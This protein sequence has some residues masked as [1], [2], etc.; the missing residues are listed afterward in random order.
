MPRPR[1]PAVGVA[2]AGRRSW[3]GRANVAGLACTLVLSLC[4]TADALLT[5]ISLRE[6][7]NLLALT[8]LAWSEKAHLKPKCRLEPPAFVPNLLFYVVKCPRGTWQLDL[9]ITGTKIYRVDG[10]P[11]ESPPLYGSSEPQPWGTVDVA[12]PAFDM[13]YMQTVHSCPEDAL[14]WNDAICATYQFDVYRIGGDL[15]NLNMLAVTSDVLSTL[16]PPFDPKT[17]HYTVTLFQNQPFAISANGLEPRTRVGIQF[18]GPASRSGLGDE[19]G[20]HIASQQRRIWEIPGGISGT[21]NF[22]YEVCALPGDGNEMNSYFI[23]VQVKPVFSAELSAIKAEGDY[24]LVPPFHV[25]IRSYQILVP[26]NVAQVSLTVRT[27][28]PEAKIS[29]TQ[30]NETGT[31]HRSGMTYAALMPTNT[32]ISFMKP[33]KWNTAI[34]LT[35]TSADGGEEQTVVVNLK[36]VMSSYSKLKNIT[37]GNGTSCVLTP[38]FQTNITQYRCVFDWSSG[39]VG[40]LIPHMDHHH[41]GECELRMPDPELEKGKYLSVVLREEVTVKWDDTEKWSRE[42]LYGES[43]HVQF[44]VVSADRYTH[45]IYDVEVLRDAPWWMRTQT[46]RTVAWWSYGLSTL[47]ALSNPGNFMQ[48]TKYVQFM[49]LT[50]DIDGVPSAYAD[51][52]HNLDKGMQIPSIMPSFDMGL[53]D[54]DDFDKMKEDMIQQIKDKAGIE[55]AKLLLQYCFASKEYGRIAGN[56]I[57]GHHEDDTKE[58]IESMAAAKANMTKDKTAKTAKDGGAEDK[59]AAKGEA[60]TAEDRLLLETDGARLRGA[61]NSSNSFGMG[62]D[63]RGELRSAISRLLSSDFE[64]WEGFDASRSLSEQSNPSAQLRRLDDEYRDVWKWSDKHWAKYIKEETDAGITMDSFPDLDCASQPIIEEIITYLML[65]HELS[66]LKQMAHSTTGYFIFTILGLVTLGSSYLMYYR[67]VMKGNQKRPRVFEPTQMWIFILDYALITFMKLCTKLIFKGKVIKIM[68]YSPNHATTVVVCY[69]LMIAYPICFVL[70]VFW[71]VNGLISQR[72]LV[73]DKDTEAWTDPKCTTLKITLK[74]KVPGFI[75]LLPQLMTNHVRSCVPILN[76]EGDRL[77]FG[78]P[79]PG[80]E[81]EDASD[82]DEGGVQD[83][84]DLEKENLEHIA[85]VGHTP[86]SMHDRRKSERLLRELTESRAIKRRKDEHMTALNKMMEDAKALRTNIEVQACPPWLHHSDSERAHHPVPEDEGSAYTVFSL[87]DLA[88]QNWKS[89]KKRHDVDRLDDEEAFALLTFVNA[90]IRDE[91]RLAK[92]NILTVEPHEGYLKPREPMKPDSLVPKEHQNKYSGDN[93]WLDTYDDYEVLEGPFDHNPWLEEFTA[94]NEYIE[95]KFGERLIYLGDDNLAKI[96]WA[97]PGGDTGGKLD[98]LSEPEE[99]WPEWEKATMKKAH[100]GGTAPDSTTIRYADKWQWIVYDK[101]ECPWY[102]DEADEGGWVVLGFTIKKESIMF[103]EDIQHGLKKFFKGRVPFMVPLVDKME[104]RKYCWA[105]LMVAMDTKLKILWASCQH[106]K[107]YKEQ[108]L[109]DLAMT[110]FHEALFQIELGQADPAKL[111]PHEQFVVPQE[112]LSY[113]IMKYEDMF[114]FDKEPWWGKCDVAKDGE[115]KV[116]F[117]HNLFW[118]K[119]GDEELISACE[120]DELVPATG[121]ATSPY[122]NQYPN[123]DFGLKRFV[124]LKPDGTQTDVEIG[125]QMKHILPLM[126]YTDRFKVSVPVSMLDLEVKNSMSIILGESKYGQ[127][128]KYAFERLTTLISILILASHPNGLICC[129]SVLS[130]ELMTFSYKLYASIKARRVE[131]TGGGGDDAGENLIKLRRVQHAEPAKE[132]PPSRENTNGKSNAKKEKETNGNKVAPEGGEVDPATDAEDGGTKELRRQGAVISENEVFSEAGEFED[133]E[134]EEEV[135]AAG[136]KPLQEILASFNDVDV[137]VYFLRCIVLSLLLVAQLKNIIAPAICAV[138][139][140]YV[141]SLTMVYM[142]VACFKDQIADVI[143][144]QKESVTAMYTTAWLQYVAIRVFL[145]GENPLGMEI[146]PF[147]AGNTSSTRAEK[148][149]LIVPQLGITFSGEPKDDPMLPIEEQRELWLTKKMAFYVHHLEGDDDS[150]PKSIRDHD[151]Y[152]H[153]VVPSLNVALSVDQMLLRQAIPQIMATIQCVNHSSSSKISRPQYDSFLTLFK[154]EDWEP[155]FEQDKEKVQQMLDGWSRQVD[156]WFAEYLG[157]VESD[158][159]NTKHIKAQLEGMLTEECTGKMHRDITRIRF[160]DVSFPKKGSWKAEDLIDKVCYISV[161]YDTESI[162][163]V[164]PA[165]RMSHYSK[166]VAITEEHDLTA[167]SDGD[168][169][170]DNKLSTPQVD[171]NDHY[172]ICQ[173]DSV[174]DVPVPLNVTKLQFVLWAQ[175][176]DKREELIC[177]SS[178]V[179][180]KELPQLRTCSVLMHTLWSHAGRN[181]SPTC[182]EDRDPEVIKREQEGDRELEMAKTPWQKRKERMTKNLRWFAGCQFIPYFRPRSDASKLRTRGVLRIKLLEMSHEDGQEDVKTVTAVKNVIEGDSA[183]NLGKLTRHMDRWIDLGKFFGVFIGAEELEHLKGHLRKITK[184]NEEFKAQGLSFEEKKKRLEKAEVRRQLADQTEMDLSLANFAADIERKD[185]QLKKQIENGIEP[186]PSHRVETKT[187]SS[188]TVYM[189][190]KKGQS[191]WPFSMCKKVEIE[192]EGG[193]HSTQNY[194]LDQLR[195]Y[196]EFSSASAKQILHYVVMSE[197]LK[198]S[199]NWR[200]DMISPHVAYM[201]TNEYDDVPSVSLQWVERFH[202]HNV[203]FDRELQGESTD[204]VIVNGRLCFKA[205]GEDANRVVKGA[206]AVYLYWDGQTRW[207]ISPEKGMPPPYGIRGHDASKFIWV[208]DNKATPDLIVEPWHT[209]PTDPSAVKKWIQDPSIGL[210]RFD[211]GKPK[212]MFMEQANAQMAEQQEGDESMVGMVKGIIKESLAEIILMFSKAGGKKIEPELKDC[213]VSLSTNYITFSWK[214]DNIDRLASFR[215][216]LLKE[217]GNYESAWVHL[218]RSIYVPRPKARTNLAAMFAKTEKLMQEAVESTK[219]PKVEKLQSM[220]SMNIE[221]LE[222]K[223]PLPV[224]DK[225]DKFGPPWPDDR[226]RRMREYINNNPL[227]NSLPTGDDDDAGQLSRKD[228]ALLV[229]EHIAAHVMDRLDHEKDAKIEAQEVRALYEGECEDEVLL[230]FRDWLMDHPI[231]HDFAAMWADLSDDLEI[232]MDDFVEAIKKDMQKFVTG[233]AF[234]K[235]SREDKAKQMFADL[236]VQFSGGISLRELI[237]SSGPTF[238]DAKKSIV[239]FQI[240]LRYIKEIREEAHKKS[241]DG[242]KSLRFILNPQFENSNEWKAFRI[243]I[244]PDWEVQPNNESI[245]ICLPPNFYELWHEVIHDCEMKLPQEFI[246]Y[247]DGE[248]EDHPIISG[249]YMRHGQGIQRWGDGRVYSG[250]WVNH[251]YDGHGSMF[252]SVEDFK[253]DHVPSY[254]GEWKEGHRNGYGVFQWDQDPVENELDEKGKIKKKAGRSVGIHKVYNGEWLDDLFHGQGRLFMG[255][256]Q[257]A[258]QQKRKSRPGFVAI[259]RTDPSTLLSFEGTFES[260][261]E[262]ADRWIRRRDEAYQHETNELTNQEKKVDEPGHREQHLRLDKLKK[263]DKQKN[264]PKF[265]KYFEVDAKKVQRAGQPLADLAIHFYRERNN[266]TKH[267]KQGLARYADGTE[268]MGEFKDGRPHGKCDYLK[269]MELKDDGSYARELAQFSGEYVSGERCG[270]GEYKTSDGLGYVGEW[271]ANMKNGQGKQVLSPNLAEAYGYTS[272]E[273]EWMDDMRH[274]QGSMVFGIDGCFLYEGPFVNDAREGKGKVYL[275]T[276]KQTGADPSRSSS[277]K[278]AAAAGK[279]F[280]GNIAMLGGKQEKRDKVLI[281]H[282]VWKANVLDTTVEPAW[283]RLIEPGETTGAFYYGTLDREGNRKGY[284]V[285]FD[286]A[287]EDKDFMKAVEDGKPYKKED[288]SDPDTLKLTMYAGTWHD[289]RPQGRGVQHFAFP[290]DKKRRGTYSGQFHEG[291][292]H[293]RGTWQTRV[294]TYRPIDTKEIENWRNDLMHG[295]GIV[296]DDK[297]VHVNVIFE[298][299]VCQMPFTDTGAP[300]MD[301]ERNQLVGK[302]VRQAKANANVANLEKRGGI[303]GARPE[304]RLKGLE[305]HE[306]VNLRN[307]LTDSAADG[308]SLGGFRRGVGALRAGSSGQSLGGNS[309]AIVGYKRQGTNG[310]AANNEDALELIREPTDLNLPDEDMYITGGEGDNEVFNGYFFKLAGTFGIPVYR[311]VKRVGYMRAISERFLYRDPKTACWVIGPVPMHGLSVLKGCA[312]VEDETHSKQATTTPADTTKN[313]YV[314]HPQTKAMR[315]FGAESSDEEDPKTGR[316]KPR[317][318]KAPV[319]LIT[320][321]S[322]VGFELLGSTRVNQRNVAD[323]LFLRASRELYGRPVYEIQTGG[324]WLYWLQDK[325]TLLEGTQGPHAPSE[326]K[327]AKSLFE[328]TGHWIVAH[329]LGDA[330][331]GRTVLAYVED[332][333]VTPDLIDPGSAWHCRI[334]E[335]PPLPN[336]PEELDEANSLK[337]PKV[338]FGAAKARSKG[339]LSPSEDGA[340]PQRTPRSGASDAGT[341]DAGKSEGHGMLSMAGSFIA[342]IADFDGDQFELCQTLRLVMEEAAAKGGEMLPKFDFDDEEKEAPPG[343]G[344]GLDDDQQPLLGVEDKAR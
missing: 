157:A 93:M 215:G 34:G 160:K 256:A 145:S 139:C 336:L 45:T 198:P 235:V 141:A 325:G 104:I 187:V 78:P 124:L 131:E 37:V 6:H 206:D 72:K 207:V 70:W 290:S 107:F 180:T 151:R 306:T 65:L 305:I 213:L 294:W 289:D 203:V 48:L 220:H 225:Q 113:T 210:V 94:H 75:P 273:G 278:K 90:H 344:V 111:L 248:Y 317:K 247:Y 174:L 39:R 106:P 288:P 52:A 253:L 239:A 179:D 281:M 105:E 137:A 32:N 114:P 43:H 300:A 188:R 165:D 84:E 331:N 77:R 196:Q 297:T 156:W 228:E 101:W 119:P 38:E 214:D 267:L 204:A 28:D 118:A 133:E 243:A 185:R 155:E 287:E 343:A 279:G 332:M 41:C 136:S 241:S 303:E 226:K 338:K 7:D 229:Y 91:E 86:T 236:D 327:E 277:R 60:A 42:F 148:V 195:S 8:A 121:Y 233:K 130:I 301:F 26:K 150:R 14:S 109:A 242:T 323:G 199:K 255:K 216:F 153:D 33:P 286:D 218:T 192:E 127:E 170:P 2:T 264:H 57:L 342:S 240:P 49:V 291:T 276:D 15:A 112:L 120:E 159:T 31:S 10:E 231:Y 171:R 252:A 13:P 11:L 299:G 116:M 285:M 128:W 154:P 201:V 88:Q 324:I 193:A 238:E 181:L 304:G 223:E 234:A 95:N 102:G 173:F 293:G 126:K 302:R 96:G 67:V 298:D 275:L 166:I 82:E 330:Y 251:L 99:G 232:E 46:T 249:T 271:A 224:I 320:V 29:V 326:A 169:E 4:S 265:E 334:A 177:Y 25:G 182:G 335:P 260:N 21:G 270:Q 202:N 100:D 143:A 197:H 318:K 212:D 308:K 92:Y 333:A 244:N 310:T 321:T 142:N 292:R 58:L 3:S 85:A 313:W 20:C 161:I 152:E 191:S 261:W 183:M 98:W 189:M 30:D 138:T 163:K 259:G 76:E 200:P 315:H 17:K 63:G 167:N 194:L 117:D 83:L 269:R 64:D 74:P 222:V 258:V 19:N 134:P 87:Y 319:D 311:I 274:G 50:T 172:Y 135:A 122:F 316:K 341:S 217:F 1:R 56:A 149:G 209:W 9:N 208:R 123:E 35:V 190:K 158:R 47:M 176:A 322:I 89:R 266:D 227:K 246:R 140:I 81:E 340:T 168:H 53:P 66:L 184:M 178:E 262:E 62:D 59:G 219:K 339:R 337:E 254:I 55:H 147:D 18:K 79:Q 283:C 162:K 282:G 205:V 5:G 97:I 329:D 272:Y 36:E 296:E 61:F 307:V 51:F 295:V 175:L 284:G 22:I 146:F 23:K 12:L 68:G 237:P 54:S 314:W 221:S 80:D 245:R 44:T 108:S 280:L 164:F 263:S 328:A 69:T 230:M 27:V 24:E 115:I 186:I 132:G 250:H 257:P 268:Y 110:S 73:Y 211:H 144:E 40:E 309:K 16:D 71:R 103:Y 312:F 129:A 125:V